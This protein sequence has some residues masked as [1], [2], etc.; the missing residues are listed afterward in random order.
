M[1]NTQ[2]STPNAERQTPTAASP[3][4]DL[5]YRTYDGPLHLRATR[6]WTIAVSRIRYLRSRWWFWLLVAL[7]VTPY[8]VI[9]LILFFQSQIPPGSPTPPNPFIDNTI[10]QRFA[11]QF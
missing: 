8:L 5:T 10:G 4:A 6:W 1:P 11:F 3:I 9:A 7:S 2:Y